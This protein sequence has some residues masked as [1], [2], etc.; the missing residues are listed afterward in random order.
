MGLP[1]QAAACLLA[2]CALA[3][4]QATTTT[5]TATGAGAGATTKTRAISITTTTVTTSRTITHTTSAA[6]RTGT[7]HVPGV[8]HIP[9]AAILLSVVPLPAQAQDQVGSYDNHDHNSE[10]SLFVDTTHPRL[11]RSCAGASPFNLTSG[12]LSSG[13]AYVAT[14]PDV[15][16]QPLRPL[17][18]AGVVDAVFSVEEGYLRWY[19][20]RFYGGR[21]RYCRDAGA[22]N[23]VFH[24]GK[25]WP[26]GC[27]E[28][29]VRAVRESACKDGVVVEG[30]GRVGEGGEA[31]TTASVVMGTGA[32]GAAGTTGVAGGWD[33]L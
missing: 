5:G 2:F 14:S 22:V 19:D 27:V 31:R 4:A 32:A 7:A 24:I 16:F 29:D 21:A 15:V 28:V 26:R 30:G 20:A 10:G 6:S 17:A 12:R 11:A 8:T 13:G 33:E 9:D 3:G 23:V 18:R 1:S 25:T